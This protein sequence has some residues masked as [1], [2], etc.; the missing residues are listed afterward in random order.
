[1][2]KLKRVITGMIITLLLLTGCDAVDAVQNG[3][4]H[5]QAISADLEKSLGMKSQVGFNWNNGVLTSVSINF[6]DLPKTHRLREIA[7]LVRKEVAHEFKQKP[8]Q[9]TI[10]FSVT[11]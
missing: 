6:Q 4:K 1:M 7:S 2:T 5:T 9:I 10:S 3:F 11:P 8:R